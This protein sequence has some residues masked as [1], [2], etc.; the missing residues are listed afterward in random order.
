M[1]RN[2]DG[3]IW[4]VAQIGREFGVEMTGSAVVSII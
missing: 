1:A 2:L 4:K 3:N